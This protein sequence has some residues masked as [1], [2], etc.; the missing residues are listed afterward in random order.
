MCLYTTETRDDRGKPAGRHSLIHRRIPTHTMS[1]RGYAVMFDVMLLIHPHLWSRPSTALVSRI[2]SAYQH[3][4]L[5]G[6]GP[7]VEFGDNFPGFQLT[8]DEA[9]QGRKVVRT[10]GV[11]QSLLQNEFGPNRG[12]LAP[13]PMA[14]EISNI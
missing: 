9:L 2:V 10:E 12:D 14:E 13:K 1:K 8:L 6:N 7:R 11:D 3:H 4:L 5:V